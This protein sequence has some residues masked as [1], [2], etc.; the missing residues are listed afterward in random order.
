MPA[1]ASMLKRLSECRIGTTAVEFALIAPVFILM[2]AG[3]LEIGRALWMG[4]AIK[5]VA[6]EAAHKA[7]VE[8]ATTAELQAYAVTRAT[9]MDLPGATFST[10]TETSGGVAMLVVNASIAYSPILKL[11]PIPPL[12]LSATAKAPAP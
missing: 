4:G 11:A 12:T 1:F 9:E 2:I 10:T 8:G 7:V 5:F 6:E 3:T